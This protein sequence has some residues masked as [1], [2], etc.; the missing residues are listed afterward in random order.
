MIPVVR[1]VT[2]WFAL[3]FSLLG[4]GVFYFERSLPMKEGLLLF[5]PMLAK[6]REIEQYWQKHRR[7]KKELPSIAENYEGYG[8][9]ISVS[10]LGV[11][12]GVNQSGAIFINLR[13]KVEGDGLVWECDGSSVGN[14]PSSCQNS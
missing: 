1:R 12:R 8:F 3:C 11:I 9:S 13:P 4:I 2:F 7:F 14:I 10:E 6:Q 5:E